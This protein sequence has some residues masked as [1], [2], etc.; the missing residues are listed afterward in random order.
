MQFETRTEE[1]G[2]RQLSLNDLIGG[3]VLLAARIV[4]LTVTVI[5][6]SLPVKRSQGFGR[7]IEAGPV[8]RTAQWTSVRS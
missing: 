2:R 7:Y 5:I 4:P 6:P 1:I 8:M 3:L